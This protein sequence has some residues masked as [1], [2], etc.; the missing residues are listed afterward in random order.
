MLSDIEINYLSYRVVPVIGQQPEIILDKKPPIVQAISPI[1]CNKDN[2]NN[3]KPN[4][5]LKDKDEV[6]FGDLLESEIEKLNSF[7]PKK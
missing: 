1:S 7:G 4:R 6:V 2:Y 3:R 5:N